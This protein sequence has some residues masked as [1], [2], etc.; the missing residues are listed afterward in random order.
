MA[1]KVF[2][3]LGT[4]VAQCGDDGWNVTFDVDLFDQVAEL[5]KP[6][7]RKQVSEAERQRLAEMSRE[8]SPFRKSPIS[9]AP[10]T[11]LESLQTVPG[12]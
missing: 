6:R 9:E 7:R 10:E 12:V 1:N 4:E 8:Y 3:I 5:V 2:A 11:H